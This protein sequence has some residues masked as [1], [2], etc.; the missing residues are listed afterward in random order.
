METAR[1]EPIRRAVRTLTTYI[2][3]LGEAK[4]LACRLAR[5]PHEVHFH[6]L[7]SLPIPKDGHCVD[8]GANRG[9]S[10]DAMRM[11]GFRHITALEPNPTLADR[12]LHR[13]AKWSWGEDGWGRERSGEIRV[14]GCGAGEHDGEMKLSIPVYNGYEFDGLGAIYDGNDV[15]WWVRTS[16]WRFDPAKYER[17]NIVCQIRRLGNLDLRPVAFMKLDVQGSELAALK[18]AVGILEADRPVLMIETPDDAICEFLAGFG[19][20][21]WQYVNRQLVR[22]REGLNVFFLPCGSQRVATHPYTV[23]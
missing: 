20:E 13:Y 6:A 21:P 22:G 10:I 9:Q 16:M 17:R 19:Y 8:V 1:R 11:M 5:R 2:P 18:G 23:V 7:R 4:Q 14:I 15:D 3:A 12:L